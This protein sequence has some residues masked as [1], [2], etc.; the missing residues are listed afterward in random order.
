MSDTFSF[1]FYAKRKMHVIMT[2]RRKE[3]AGKQRENK[4]N[5][6]S[7][8]QQGGTMSCT[9]GQERRVEVMG[10]RREDTKESTSEPDGRTDGAIVVEMHKRQGP[11]KQQPERSTGHEVRWLPLFLGT[12]LVSFYPSR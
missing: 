8:L 9:G 11:P 3:N 2:K 5:P 7:K 4:S 1:F 10:R 12:D 6:K